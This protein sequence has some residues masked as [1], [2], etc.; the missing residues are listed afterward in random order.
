MQDKAKTKQWARFK[1]VVF[2]AWWP[3][4]LG[5]KILKIPFVSRTRSFVSCRG[6]GLTSNLLKDFFF[7]SWCCP[8]GYRGNGR[9]RKVPLDGAIDLLS[10]IRHHIQTVSFVWSGTVQTR[11][12]QECKQ[13]SLKKPTSIFWCHFMYTYGIFSQ[14]RLSKNFSWWEID[15]KT[16]PTH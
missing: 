12:C 13:K 6:R 8:Q 7:N 10:Q 14:K 4:H 11:A 16:G 5:G 9:R 2:K 1:V 3:N 15:L